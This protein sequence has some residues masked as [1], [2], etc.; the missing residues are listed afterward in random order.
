MRGWWRLCALAAA[1]VLFGS[2]AVAAEW[3]KVSDKDGVLVERR[4][5]AGS[6][7]AEVRATAR[8]E[9][10]PSAIFETVWNHSEYTQFVPHLRRLDIL[11]DTGDERVTYEQVSVP[12]VSDRDYAVRLHK[13]VDAAAQRYEIDFATANDLAPPSDGRHERVRSIRGSWLI[14]PGPGGAGS[15]VRYN[16][17]SDP[18]GSIPAWIANRAQRD[19][20]AELVRAMLKRAQEKSGR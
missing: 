1:L 2:L 15:V 12:L 3:E 8:S 18:G 16:V 20:V 6:P 5:V 14:E 17:V 4:P 13:R 19:T 9:L 10:P 7:F 11:S